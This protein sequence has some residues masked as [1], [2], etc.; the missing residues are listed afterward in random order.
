MEGKKDAQTS[1]VGSMHS[2]AVIRR[3]SGKTEVH[4]GL[5]SASNITDNYT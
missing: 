5:Q 2:L 1:S 4:R 3:Y